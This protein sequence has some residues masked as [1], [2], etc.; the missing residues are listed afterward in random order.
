MLPSEMFVNLIDMELQEKI[1]SCN[2][3]DKDAMEALTTLLGQ[4]SN[5]LKNE[6]ED[7]SIERTNGKNMLFYKGKN[8]IPKDLHLRRYIVK[9]HHDAKT[10]GHPGE[11]ETYNTVRQHYWWPGMRTF[12]NNYVESANNSRSTEARP[13]LP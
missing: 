6:L 3:L 9:Q 2:N 13:N 12:V 11:L 8:Y 4:E 7:W 5:L 1:S 10:A